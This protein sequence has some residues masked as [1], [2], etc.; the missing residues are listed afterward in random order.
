[1]RRQVR[2]LYTWSTMAVMCCATGRAEETE[3]LTVTAS[4]PPHAWLVRQ[5][6]GDHVR[7]LTMVRPGED[8]HTYQPSDAQVSQVMGGR[9]YFRSGVAFESGPWFRALSTSTQVKVR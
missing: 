6:G 9:L 5:I 3:R 2:V 4:I 1:M 7:V 8:P